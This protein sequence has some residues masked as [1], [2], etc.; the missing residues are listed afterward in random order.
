M[1]LRTSNVIETIERRSEE[2]GIDNAYLFGC[3]A[4]V[5]ENDNKKQLLAVTCPPNF[6]VGKDKIIR[7]RDYGYKK[8]HNV[9]SYKRS[10]RLVTMLVNKIPDKQDLR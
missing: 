2:F 8:K 7:M 1:L 10:A 9:D 4:I 5:S 6:S 3:V